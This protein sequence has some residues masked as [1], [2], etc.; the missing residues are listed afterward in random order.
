[1]SLEHLSSQDSVAPKDSYIEKLGGDDGQ[2]LEMCLLC[3]L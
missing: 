3:R 2:L 1:M